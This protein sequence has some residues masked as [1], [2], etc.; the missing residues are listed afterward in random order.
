MPCWGSRGRRRADRAEKGVVDNCTLGH[1]DHR[2][3]LE[4]AW[5][6]GGGPADQCEGGLWLDSACLAKGPWQ[7]SSSDQARDP[8]SQ[9]LSGRRGQSSLLSH[10]SPRAQ[11]PSAS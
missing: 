4:V 1:S 5:E 2:H 9:A 7:S 3:G 8:E 11:T 6:I 10:A